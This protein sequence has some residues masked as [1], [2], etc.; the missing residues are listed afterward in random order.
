MKNRHHS[1]FTLIELA[2]AIFI[3][4]LLLGSILVPLA[5]QVET[6][7]ISETQKA[8]EEI[9][10]ALYGFAATNGYLPCPDLEAG[11][12][13]N[14]GA[15]DISAGGTGLCASVVVAGGTTLSAGNLPWATL[16][17]GNQ[18]AWGNRFRYTVLAAYAQRSPAAQ[19]SLATAG[20]L[21]VCPTG[22]CATNFT[23]TAVAVVISH[24]KNGYSAYS[25]ITNTQNT[26]AT[27]TDELENADNDRDA[28]SRTQS[29]VTG[30]EF[31]DIV[32]WLPKFNLNNRMV[33]AG[34]LP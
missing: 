24:G 28:V 21:R 25:A 12:G 13:A 32:V 10:D 14:D 9:R 29:N 11:A 16:G 3:I 33:S 27:S 6:R 5:T 30:S 15:E 17:L 8:I 2:V 31:D 23:T 20:G 1:G 7:Q 26:L 18:D 19:F 34:R 4:A 22:A